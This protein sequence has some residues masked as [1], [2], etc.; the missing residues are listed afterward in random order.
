MKY[1]KDTW[2]NNRRDW[3][4]NQV[5]NKH[6]THCIYGMD[7]YDDKGNFKSNTRKCLQK[8]CVL[9]IVNII[10]LSIFLYYFIST[11]LSKVSKSVDKYPKLNLD[12]K[13]KI[14]MDEEIFSIMLKFKKNNSIKTKSVTNSAEFKAFKLNYVW[15]NFVSSCLE[16][17]IFLDQYSHKTEK[18]VKNLRDIKVQNARTTDPDYHAICQIWNV[19]WRQPLPLSFRTNYHPDLDDAPTKKIEPSRTQTGMLS[20]FEHVHF[21]FVSIFFIQISNLIFDPYT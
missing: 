2:S 16:R 4:K 6:Q 11:A 20:H 21:N 14:S 15:R 1:V 7:D 9:T 5:D 19:E 18:Q 8:H 3:I 17:P 12:D 13:H 10:F